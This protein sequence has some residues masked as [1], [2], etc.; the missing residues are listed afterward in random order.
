MIIRITVLISLMASTAFAELTISEGKFVFNGVKQEM[1]WA[2][3]C[4]KLPAIV[5]YH[6]SGQGGGP[7]GLGK[8][9]EW[10][11]FN[12]SLGVMGCRGLLET[13]GW[14][15]CESGAQIDDGKPDN[16]M[17]GSEPRD[18][19]FWD[20]Q[21]LR[22][23]GRP[24]ALTG[25]GQAT[26]RWFFETSQETGFM[27][28]LVIVATLKHDG[29]SVEQQQHVIRQTLVAMRELQKEFPQALILANVI[30]EHD[31]HSDWDVGGVNGVNMLAVRN[32][33]WKNEAGQT[34]VSLTSPGPGFEPEQWAGG[35]VIVD[36][37]GSNRISYEV[38]PEAGRFRGAFVHP[39]RDESWHIWP[40]PQEREWMVRDARGMPWGA[41]ESMFSVDPEDEARASGWYRGGAGDRW[42]P[43]CNRYKSFLDHIK[44]ESFPERN[45]ATGVVTPGI[46]YFVAHDEK[47]V[48]SD[49]DWPRAETCFERWA[50]T[51][52]EGTDTPPPP[53]KQLY[54]DPI[55]DGTY[56]LVLARPADPGGL[57][58]YNPFFR[59][60]VPQR[61]L[62]AC[63]DALEVVLFESA[64]YQ[65]RFFH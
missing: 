7:Y 49:V 28:E 39:T 40:D 36:G 37:G 56:K 3:S 34:R 17:F 35:P 41:T 21:A 11:D 45:A 15:K 30:N 26:L 51:N 4:F 19:G 27:F 25:I 32:D 38:G 1:V 58:A 47:G 18:Q 52:L 53:E 60:C 31:A 50:K 48:Q 65:E 6:F 61:G 13:Q 57:E 5:T 16:C 43:D 22:N 20:V 46:A 9:R 12:Q 8:A 33:R 64:E 63:I 54:Y 14:A 44:N 29:V 55:I 2:R 62:S 42:T 10:V 24:T 23:G 59:E